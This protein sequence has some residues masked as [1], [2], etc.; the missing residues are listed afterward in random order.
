M[1]ITIPQW[2]FVAIAWAGLLLILL[3]LI[4]LVINRIVH[5]MKWRKIW[6]LARVWLTAEKWR[7]DA[8]E[9]SMSTFEDVVRIWHKDSPQDFEHMRWRMLYMTV[10]PPTPVAVADEMQRVSDMAAKVGLIGASYTLINMA[11][12]ICKDA[13]TPE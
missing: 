7:K 12:R 13:S 3:L 1:T 6:R 10:E 8:K 9:Y 5:V 4:G 11:Q 2:P